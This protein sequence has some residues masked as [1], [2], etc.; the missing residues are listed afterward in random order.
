MHPR[1]DATHWLCSWTSNDWRKAITD[2]EK[3]VPNSICYALVMTPCLP[4]SC[5][6]LC[7]VNAVEEDGK[8][9]G[10]TV[11]VYRPNTNLPPCY[12]RTRTCHPATTEHEPATLL[13]P[14]T[15]LPPCYDQTRTC[16][17]ATTE[18]EPATLLRITKVM[19]IPDSRSVH[20]STLRLTRGVYTAAQGVGDDGGNVNKVIGGT[21]DT[22]ANNTTPRDVNFR[23]KM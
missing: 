23:K 1:L 8:G 15:N 18:H 11:Y 4:L 19:E 9:P 6:E 14:N 2:Y 7:N 13:R 17:P 12:D 22:T 20:H 16:H 3:L 10:W 5:K 21:H